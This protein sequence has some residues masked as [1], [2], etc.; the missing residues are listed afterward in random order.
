MGEL[1]TPAEYARRR[2][3][4]G[5]PG[6]SAQG[7]HKAILA[8][9]ITPI[10]GK[11]DPDVAD[12]QWAKHTRKRVDYH[13]DQST[14]DP[15]IPTVGKSTDAGA[16]WADSKARTEA[17]VAALKE[18]ELARKTSELVGR[19]G[20]EH[21]AYQHGRVLQKAIIDTFPARIAMEVVTIKDPWDAERFIRAQL[22]A[23]FAGIVGADTD[24][25]E[26]GNGK[27]KP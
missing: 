25:I 12:I 8:G 9:R 5:L 6:G 10:N 24:P 4:R 3:S 13:A 20:V 11:I 21:A 1:I 22:R 23:E 19:E 2:K 14:D 27:I 15:P 18:L 7:V 16:T 26:K 17:A